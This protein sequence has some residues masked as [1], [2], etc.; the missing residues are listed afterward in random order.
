[1]EDETR[2]IKKERRI[3]KVDIISSL[4][5]P[6][7]QHIMSFLPFKQ[8]V[9]TS[10]LSKVWRQAWFSFPILEFDEFMIN[11]SR[12]KKA[13][14]IRP[15]WEQILQS[16]HRNMVGVRKMTLKTYSRTGDSELADRCATYA[17][18][19]NVKELVLQ[20]NQISSMW[21]NLPPIVLRSKSINVL[22]LAGCK[23]ELPRSDLKLSLRKLCLHNVHV[24]D[25][26]IN[27]VFLRCGFIED[28]EVIKCQGFKRLKLY[29]LSKLSKITLYNNDDL[30][31]LKI[32][33]LNA[34]S[35]LCIRSNM[36]YEL[37]IC[38]RLTSLSL[39]GTNR[40]DSISFTEEWLCTNIYRLPLLEKLSISHFSNIERM[41]ISSCR[42]KSLEI[43][44]CIKLVEVRFETPNLSRFSYAG[45][46]I[47]S[48][49]SSAALTLSET[50][51]FFVCFNIDP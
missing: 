15:Y 36:P 23:L 42:L 35:S 17:I 3:D 26:V 12:E 48:F 10:V 21:Y 40:I 28:V 37:D 29:G 18:E 25:D 43:S 2:E 4:P 13:F 33:S 41:K 7:L 34:N 19:N 45:D 22:K 9:Q 20:I 50:H 44:V 32:D 27:N 24:D 14:P 5:E 8:V 47:I 31:H 39:S 46:V 49:S 38:K 16:R 11:S 51:L 6:L 30:R 1:M